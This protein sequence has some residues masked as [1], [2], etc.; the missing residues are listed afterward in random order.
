MRASAILVAATAAVVALA[1][2]VAHADAQACVL[3]DTRRTRVWNNNGDNVKDDATGMIRMVDNV[4]MSDGS[5]AYWFRDI[6]YENNRDMPCV[7]ISNPNVPKVE[8]RMVQLLLESEAPGLGMCV[9]LDRPV[10]N[11]DN[12]PFKAC[13]KGRVR[14]CFRG[15]ITF[16]STAADKGTVLR[17]YCDNSCPSSDKIVRFNVIYSD[18]TY[19]DSSNS[20]DNWC[21]TNFPQYYSELISKANLNVFGADA[22]TDDGNFASATVAGTFVTF[23]FA[24]IATLLML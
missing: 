18:E 22:Q 13:G 14:A 23:F 11:V 15:E 6:L 16:P 5:Q 2:F 21:E 7:S 19:D 17:V 3:S 24:S 10:T 1:L 20:L 8:K 12:P 4:T 9:Q